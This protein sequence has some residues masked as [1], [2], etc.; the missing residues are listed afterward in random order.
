MSVIEIAAGE[1]LP[2]HL[3]QIVRVSHNETKVEAALQ[4]YEH[5]ARLTRAVA[6]NPALEKSHLHFNFG[7]LTV[8]PSTTVTVGL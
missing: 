2:K 5:H 8:P 6:A 3:G 1:L 7:T 4:G